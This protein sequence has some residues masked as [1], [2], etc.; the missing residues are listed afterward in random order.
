M[1]NHILA[2]ANEN[3]KFVKVSFPSSDK[4][5]TY[6]TTL[7]VEIDDNLVVPVGMQEELKVVTVV[8]IVNVW[9]I[10]DHIKY[11]WVVQKVDLE[12]YEDCKA[13]EQEAV[14]ALN[15]LK[16]SKRRR[17]MLNELEATL[18][19]GTTVTLTKLVRL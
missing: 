5:H 3:L 13:K 18:G 10:D 8:D 6:K 12:H 19:E 17:E 14:V 16:Y 11:K 9:E 1:I 2:E 4:L 7:D 15:R